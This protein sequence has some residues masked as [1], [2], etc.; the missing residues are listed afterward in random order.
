MAINNDFNIELKWKKLTEESY[1]NAL[2]EVFLPMKIII[3][4]IELQE[5]STEKL[6]SFLK[7]LDTNPPKRVPSQV[8]KG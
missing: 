8:E 6:V 3:K 2:H 7:I 1:A 5:H 4:I